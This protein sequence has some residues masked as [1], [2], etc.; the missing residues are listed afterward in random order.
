MHRTKSS[1]LH[2]FPHQCS[3][4][5]VQQI[6]ISIRRK[7]RKGIISSPSHYP[8]N[9]LCANLSVPICISLSLSSTL[10]RKIR[11]AADLL[12]AMEVIRGDVVTEAEEDVV[13]GLHHGGSELLH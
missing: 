9:S 3:C 11:E 1:H 10:E 6:K 13:A 12:G 8:P 2:S 5:T 4:P 7:K